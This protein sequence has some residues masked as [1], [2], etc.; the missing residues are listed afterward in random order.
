VTTG[1]PG[2][3]EGSN[4]RSLAAVVNRMN[5]GK[6]NC[7]GSVTLQPDQAGTTVTDSRA[8][9]GSFIGLTPLTANAAAEMAA[10]TLFVA[11]RASGG[12][13]LIHANSA[14]SDR[15]FAY[16]VIG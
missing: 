11:S 4:A 15:S 7:T 2:A 9:A 13:T 1:F 10:G 14:Q 12:F 6:L 3:P 16:V 5:R 8:T